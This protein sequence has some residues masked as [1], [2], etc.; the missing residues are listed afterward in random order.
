M[1]GKQEVD[2]HAITHK[3]HPCTFF[4][5]SIVLQVMLRLYSYKG[6]GSISNYENLHILYRHPSIHLWRT[7]KCEIS[8]LF[9]FYITAFMTVFFR[10]LFLQHSAKTQEAQQIHYCSHTNIG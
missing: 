5:T 9:M 2:C 8:L 1:S 6:W 7:Y 3:T 10:Y 4:I